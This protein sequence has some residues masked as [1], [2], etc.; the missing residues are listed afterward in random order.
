[1]SRSPIAVT[2]APKRSSFS[3]WKPVVVAA[4]IFSNER[5]VPSE[6]KSGRVGDLVG[7][8]VGDFVGE[9]LGAEEERREGKSGRKEVKE[10]SEG[11]KEV[12]ERRQEVKEGR[13]AVKEGRK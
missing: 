11:R 3:N 13:Q 2:A 4:E 9:A 5:A 12:K 1:L 10:G 7:D 6:Y 8:S